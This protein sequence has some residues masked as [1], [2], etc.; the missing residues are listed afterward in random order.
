MAALGITVLK[1]NAPWGPFTRAQIDDLVT[2]LDA[3]IAVVE[4]Q[5]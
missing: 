2:I 4:S 3:S 5:L 1:N